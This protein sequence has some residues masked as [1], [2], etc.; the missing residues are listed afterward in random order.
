MSSGA[1]ILPGVG[2]NMGDFRTDSRKD[3]GQS[4]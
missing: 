3:G 1:L 4:T 2:A